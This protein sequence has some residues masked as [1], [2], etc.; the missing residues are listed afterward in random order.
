MD[1]VHPGTIVGTDLTRSTDAAALKSAGL[2]DEQGPVID[3]A[4]NLKTVPKGAA[5]KVWCATRP[6][7][8]GQGGAYCE[9]CDIA[10][11][12]PEELAD[13]AKG[14]LRLQAAGLPQPPYSIPSRIG[15][16]RQLHFA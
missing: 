6:K 10:M 8:E 5:T 12:V 15:P 3:P 2:M 7:L 13:D 9:N 16:Y 11:L 14:G 1:S 4:K